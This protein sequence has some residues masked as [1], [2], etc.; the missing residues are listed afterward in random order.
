MARKLLILALALAL[1][2]GLGGPA[3]APEVAAGGTTQQD[4]GGSG[5]E[6]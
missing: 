3:F 6:D 4:I 1:A 5:P 2:L